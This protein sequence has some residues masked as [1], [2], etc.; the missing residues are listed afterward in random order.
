MNELGELLTLNCGLPNSVAPVY[1]DVMIFSLSVLDIFRFPLQVYSPP[2]FHSVLYRLTH[3][4]SVLLSSQPSGI[5]H[6]IAIWGVVTVYERDKC[7]SLT[8]T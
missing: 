2:R 8:R 6:P 4:G 3:V 5:H 7:E 1:H